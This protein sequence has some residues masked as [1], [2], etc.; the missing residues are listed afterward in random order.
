[1][2]TQGEPGD[3]FYIVRRGV[4]SCTQQDADGKVQEVARAFPTRRAAFDPLAKCSVGAASECGVGI[5]GLMKAVSETF[6]GPGPLLGNSRGALRGASGSWGAFGE[7]L[8]L[9]LHDN[10]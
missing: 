6:V 4:A 3:S 8:L 7:L 1:M 9:L 5:W 2:C 10:F